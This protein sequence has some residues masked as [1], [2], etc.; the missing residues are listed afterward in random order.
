MTP[1][2][3]LQAQG[4]SKCFNEGQPNEITAVRGVSLSIQ[5]GEV[6]VLEG[7]SGCGKTTLLTLLG[8]M[9][10]PTE[11]RVLLDG[12]VVSSLPEHHRAALRR[13]EFGFVFQRFNLVPGLDV[14]GNVMLPVLP[15]GLAHPEAVTRARAALRRV[16]MDHRAGERVERLSGGEMQRTAIARALI[17]N[18][19]IVIADEP[20]AS[21]DGVLAAQFLDVVAGLKAEGRTVLMSSH[22]PRVARAAVVDRCIGLLDGGLVEL[23]T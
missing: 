3:L 14:L 6:V 2:P 16:A 9:A 4:V 13:R 19:R 18:P 21:L 20:T 5:A 23:A 8:A 10:R 22:D 12:Q 11:G 17:G 1:A 15:L 7:P